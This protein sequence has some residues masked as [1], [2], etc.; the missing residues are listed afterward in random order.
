MNTYII[1]GVRTPIGSY[2]GTLS[3][4][5]LSISNFASRFYPQPQ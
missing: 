1:D 5:P 3:T 2:K 4:I